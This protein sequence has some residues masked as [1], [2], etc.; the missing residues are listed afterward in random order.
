MLKGFLAAMVEM[1]YVWAMSRIRAF[2]SFTALIVRFI[3]LQKYSIALRASYSAAHLEG[4]F[5]GSTASC[6]ESLHSRAGV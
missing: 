3:G 6:H 2:A 5:S 1:H 4:L